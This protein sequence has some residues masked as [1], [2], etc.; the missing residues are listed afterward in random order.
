[1][2]EL[3]TVLEDLILNI[4]KTVKSAKL[5]LAKELRFKHLKMLLKTPIL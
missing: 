3:N 1:M 5:S 4:E 2:G